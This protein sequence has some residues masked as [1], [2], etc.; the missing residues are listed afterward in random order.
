M[1]EKKVLLFLITLTLIQV[2]VTVNG[3]TP[4]DYHE[5]FWGGGLNVWVHYPEEA[6]PGDS[7][8]VNVYIVSG[9]YPRGN[10]VQEVKAKISVLTSTSPVVLHDSTLI[11]N[12]YIQSGSFHN[13]S[14]PITLPS[15]ARWFMSI[16]IDTLSFQQD[17]TNRQEG[18]VILDA[19]QIRTSTYSDLQQQIQELQAFMNTATNP[20]NQ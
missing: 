1:K 4:G 19:T 7:I 3:L 16:Q 11:S 8:T 6:E 14:I 18:H 13:Q 2:T 9:K 17:Q 12:T 15:D 20:E 10:H 5:K